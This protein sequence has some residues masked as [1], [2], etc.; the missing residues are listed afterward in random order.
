[1]KGGHHVFLSLCTAAAMLAPAIG[2]LPLPAL[3]A[4]L[5]GIFVGSL[6]PDAD[7]ADASIYHVRRGRLGPLLPLFGYTIRY[8]IYYPLTCVFRIVFGSRARPRHRG[9]LHSA[10]GVALASLLLTLYIRLILLGLGL[11]GDSILTLFGAGFF[12][13]CILHLLEDSCTPMGVAWW[14]PFRTTRLTGGIRT[15]SGD[16]RPLLFGIAL[17]LAAAFLLAAPEM[18]TLLQNPVAGAAVAIVLWSVFL[19]AAGVHRLT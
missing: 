19:A 12:G 14:F 4:V 6:A 8:L 16:L 7:A 5:A 1:M 11:P 18:P 13:G 2:V 9:L 15:R 3:G 17:A 10:V